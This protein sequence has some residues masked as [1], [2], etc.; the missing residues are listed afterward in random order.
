MRLFVSDQVTVTTVRAMMV[1]S[2]WR[3]TRLWYFIVW[4]FFVKLRWM[5]ATYVVSSF[6]GTVLCEARPVNATQ[7]LSRPKR[8]RANLPV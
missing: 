1:R 2:W 7:A 8:N 5:R 3:E 6:D 4:L